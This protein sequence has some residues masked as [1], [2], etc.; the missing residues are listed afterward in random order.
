MIE[1]I[2][3]GVITYYLT[4][5]VIVYKCSWRSMLGC[6]GKPPD[7]KPDAPPL[8]LDASVP[9]SVVGKST[10]VYI[11]PPP[12]QPPEPEPVQEQEPC[13]DLDQKELD[14]AAEAATNEE[15]EA[16]QPHLSEEE[17]VFQ[18]E[19]DADE[20]DYFNY[21]A[22]VSFEI[23]PT[24]QKVLTT[25]DY[26]EKEEKE[27]AVAV[28]INRANPFIQGIIKKIPDGEKKVDDLLQK[29]LGNFYQD[30]EAERDNQGGNGTSKEVN[31]FNIDNYL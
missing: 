8:A 17:K 21:A 23:L 22:G 19:R 3:I 28:G 25:D 2:I 15:V 13:S 20:E 16:Q 14:E 18:F 29:R 4:L 6:R 7:D 10:F 11:P 31:N 27:T 26:T 9:C 12:E 24:V 5:F 1:N 30:G